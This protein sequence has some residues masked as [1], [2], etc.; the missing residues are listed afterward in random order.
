MNK[1]KGKIM[2]DLDKKY[3]LVAFSFPCVDQYYIKDKDGNVIP[4][5]MTGEY[6]V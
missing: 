6:L 3:H 2:E 1:M 4:Q 5:K